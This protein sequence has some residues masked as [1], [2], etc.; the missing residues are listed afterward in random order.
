VATIWGIRSALQLYDQKLADWNE[1][2]LSVK[3]GGISLK[4]LGDS[5]AV[6]R[7]AKDLGVLDQVLL[8]GAA[9]DI[10][11]AEQV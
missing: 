10:D 11:V 6:V 3:G 8:E 4:L 2:T 1:T 9:I 5:V 7:D